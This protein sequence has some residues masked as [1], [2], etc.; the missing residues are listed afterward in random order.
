MR[1][2]HYKQNKAT[3]IEVLKKHLVGMTDEDLH[4][5]SSSALAGLSAAI[6]LEELEKSD[7]PPQKDVDDLK[8]ASAL[9]NKAAE[10]LSSIGYH[11]NKEMKRILETSFADAEA[12]IGTFF[13][14]TS[15]PRE[16]RLLIGHLC[17]ISSAL[18]GAADEVNLQ[19]M[20]L[21]TA[22]GEGPEYESFGSLTKPRK[23][24]AE[25]LARSLAATWLE[26]SG[27]PPT[28][29]TDPYSNRSEAYGPFLDLVSD[30]FDAL[31]IDAS[32]ERFAREA[33][34]DFSS[35]N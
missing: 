9:I 1:I 28:V 20:S 15:G 8:K 19:G 12:G 22:F 10:K 6:A 11:G 27:R 35:R 2:D 34:K 24:A 3:L 14:E 5:A 17:S 31:K 7:R 21:N 33:C 32:A 16:K 25:R 4:L 18:Q 23:I 29:S 13:Y 30:A 26:N